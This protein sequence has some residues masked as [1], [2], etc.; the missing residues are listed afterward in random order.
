LFLFELRHLRNRYSQRRPIEN[1]RETVNLFSFL[2]RV[3]SRDSRPT[4]LE[5]PD[6]L[7]D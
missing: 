3:Y 7:P 1:Q 5:P 2:L 6:A 4:L